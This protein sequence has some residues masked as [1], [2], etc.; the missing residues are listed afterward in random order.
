MWIYYSVGFVPLFN[1]NTNDT[2]NEGILDTLS[3][4]MF[5]V[6]PTSLDAYQSLPIFTILYGGALTYLVQLALKNM[7]EVFVS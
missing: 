6:N 5:E 3:T 2:P 1:L 4:P 7:T